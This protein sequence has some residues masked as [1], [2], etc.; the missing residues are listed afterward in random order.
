MLSVKK[1]GLNKP[2]FKLNRC[3]GSGR[4]TAVAPWGGT[5]G[6]A[7]ASAPGGGVVGWQGIR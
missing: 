2:S 4:G 7:G 5:I 6:G 3:V 1:K